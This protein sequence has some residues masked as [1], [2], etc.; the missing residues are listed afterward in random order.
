MTHAT[1]V[2][3]CSTQVEQRNE[4]ASRINTYRL[5][6]AKMRKKKKAQTVQHT[7]MW[8]RTATSK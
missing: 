8:K 6:D 7:Q 5:L 4:R 2:K 3:L 1:V